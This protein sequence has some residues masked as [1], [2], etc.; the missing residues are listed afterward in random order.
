MVDANVTYLSSDL[1]LVQMAME[2]PRAEEKVLRRVY[3]KIRQIV[4]FAVGSRREAD[5]IAQ[6]AAI[7]VVKSLGN[8]NGTGS[9]ESWAG[10]IAYRV[11]MRTVKKEH[12]KRKL[13]S[14][15]WEGDIPSTDNPERS[16]SQQQ[17]FEKLLSKMDKIPTRRR[18]PILLH[19]IYGYT[20]REV[21]ELTD[22]SPNT[23]KD[24]LKTAYRELRTIMDKHPKLRTALLE[25]IV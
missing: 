12:Q 5:D 1:E 8:F 21:A 4:R 20:V 11:T 3:P 6:L 17:L 9:I 22:A 23:V 18:I 25:E 2:D 15:L 13:L 16:V 24:R 14:P 7:E 10:R 19:L